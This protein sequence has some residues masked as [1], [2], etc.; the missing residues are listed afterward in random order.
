MGTAT[1][2]GEPGLVSA[3]GTNLVSPRGRREPG[4]VSACGTNVVSPCSRC[5]PGLVSLSERT[6]YCLEAR[7]WSRIRSRNERGIIF[8]QTTKLLIYASVHPPAFNAGVHPR[9]AQP[10]RT[11]VVR[12]PDG[13]S[14]HARWGCAPGLV[15]APG[16]N[17]VALPTGTNVSLLR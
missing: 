10:R 1:M 5:E 15:S 16:T 6:W 7:T 3:C 2:T 11:N 4:L 9:P 8:I 12:S 13:M 14:F 17:M